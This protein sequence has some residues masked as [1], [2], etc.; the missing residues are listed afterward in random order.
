MSTKSKNHNRMQSQGQILR[1]IHRLIELIARRIYLFIAFLKGPAKSQPPIKDLTLLCSATTL[2][3]KIR[4]KQV[5][6]SKYL[7]LK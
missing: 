3:L 2:A 7:S 5:K 4:N 6:L 1:V